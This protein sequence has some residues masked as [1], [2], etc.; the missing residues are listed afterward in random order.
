MYKRHYTYWTQSMR[1]LDTTLKR[2]LKNGVNL[3]MWYTRNWQ[4]SFSNSRFIGLYRS[5]LLGKH[6]SCLSFFCAGSPTVPKKR[7]QRK[8]AEKE[9]HRFGVSSNPSFHPSGNLTHIFEKR[10]R[11]ECKRGKVGWK[12]MSSVGRPYALFG[13]VRFFCPNTMSLFSYN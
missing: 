11:N 3:N 1:Q 6:K 12:K 7:K 4:N 9:A 10:T 8:E 5:Y 13:D 2:F